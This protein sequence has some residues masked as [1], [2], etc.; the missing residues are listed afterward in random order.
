VY[1]L[2]CVLKNRPSMKEIMPGKIGI[3]SF[4]AVELTDAA[5]RALAG[6]QRDLKTQAPPGAVR[7]TRPDSIHLTLQFLGDILPE[8][9]EAVA[10][11]LDAACAGRAPFAFELAGAGVFPNLNRPRVVWVGVVEPSGALA[12][13]QQRVAQALAPLGFSPEERAFTPHLTI[14][15]AARDA[16]PRDLAALGALVARAGIGSLGRVDV[17]H[18]NLMK[19]NLKPDGAVYTP[20]AVIPLAK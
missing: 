17:D 6:V 18:V 10:G 8:Q 9:V 14:G 19:S 2:G 1:N 7:W 11:A 4:V 12:A 20:L 5:R 16:G 15:R 13:L 3:R